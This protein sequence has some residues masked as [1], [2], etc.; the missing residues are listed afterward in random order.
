MIACLVDEAYCYLPGFLCLLSAFI[1][2]E[3]SAAF[4]YLVNLNEQA[5]MDKSISICVYF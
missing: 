3:F 2:S 4:A 1:N 5:E